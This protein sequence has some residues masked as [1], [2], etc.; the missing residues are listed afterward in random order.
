MF[1]SCL[2][3]YQS[4]FVSVVGYFGV[5]EKEKLRYFSTS[6]NVVFKPRYLLQYDKF[7]AFSKA[8]YK[9]AKISVKGRIC[10]H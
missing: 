4:I 9:E 1:Y 5:L 2:F 3:Y 8:L 6:A 10:L 7:L